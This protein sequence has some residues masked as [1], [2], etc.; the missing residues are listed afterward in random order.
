M[1][2]YYLVRRAKWLE[3]RLA[4]TNDE[5]PGHVFDFNEYN[6]LRKAFPLLG[7]KY[8]PAGAKPAAVSA[9]AEEEQPPVVDD[10]FIPGERATP[11]QTAKPVRKRARA[12]LVDER[13]FPGRF[14]P[15]GL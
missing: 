13:R 8:V 3:K 15:G 14:I 10:I 9:V 12:E 4:Q 7:I 2:Y 1:E 6:E 5:S 11:R